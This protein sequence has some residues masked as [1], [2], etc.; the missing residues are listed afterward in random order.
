VQSNGYQRS[1]IAKFIDNNRGQSIVEFALVLPI[2]ILLLL[3]IVD[4]GQIFCQKL[5]VSEAARE[6]V[7]VTVASGDSSLGIAA[8]GKIGAF[9][10]SINNVKKLVIGD[11]VTATVSTPVVIVDPLMSKILGTTYTVSTTTNM[12]LEVAPIK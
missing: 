10:V 6:A 11:N 9:N 12:R 8:A 1:N 3:G 5:L 4:F 2:L 7:R